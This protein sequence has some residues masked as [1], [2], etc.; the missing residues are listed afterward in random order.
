M[1]PYQEA[2]ERWEAE[3][4]DLEKRV[5]ALKHADNDEDR[6]LFNQLTLKLAILRTA[7]PPGGRAPTSCTRTAQ[8]AGHA[9]PPPRRPDEAGGRG[10]PGAAGRAGRGSSLPPPTPTAKTTGRRLWLAR[11]IASP[12]N[13]L[14][15][16]V[17]VNR[18]WQ[19]HFGRGIVGT[20]NDFGVMG[21]E[22]THPELL[23]WLADRFVDDG[24]PLKTLHRLIVL[25]NTYQTSAAL[26]G[27]DA[28]GRPDGWRCSAAGGSGGWRPRWCATRSW[29]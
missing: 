29:R 26:D 4:Q 27:G 6:R 1:Q 12:D 16:R 21:D 17:M 19:Y 11:W 5:D 10:R 28:E 8:G 9:R 14:T 20:P 22:P 18:V 7:R 15:A 24:W 13:P 3:L 2:Q 25:S 23:D